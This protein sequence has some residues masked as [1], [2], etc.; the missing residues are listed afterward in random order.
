MDN[1]ELEVDNLTNDLAAAWDN[2][3]QAAE[4]EASV[5]EDDVSHETPEEDGEPDVEEPTEEAP[6]EAELEVQDDSAEDVAPKSLSPM[7]REAW[8]NTPPE[9]RQEIAKREADFQRGIQKYAENAKRA[10]A[11]DASLAPYSQLFAKN[12]G[13]SEVLPG[14]LQTASVLQMGAPAQKAQM[15][16]QLI[17][18]FGVDIKTLDNM[19]VGKGPTQEVQ[20]QTEIE[21]LLNQKLQPLQQQLQTYQQREMQQQQEAQQAVSTEIASFAS[22]PNNE[23]YQDVKMDM[24]DIMDM[25]ATRGRNMTLKEAYDRA[26]ALHPQV[27]QIINNRQNSISVQNK[28]QAASSIS[29]ALGGPG[30]Q[31]P[32]ADLRSAIEMAWNTAGR[33]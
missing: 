26:C 28:R 20:Q 10:E 15:V 27:S 32:A 22:D 7:A 9:M 16:A 17:Q 12:G 24:A 6:P 19:L 13:P 5:I 2:I 4:E 30:G 31:E 1:N 25:A 11:M 29:G 3:E 23:F 21:Q 18:Q 8:K 14:L 33:T